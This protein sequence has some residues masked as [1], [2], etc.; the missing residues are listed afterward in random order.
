MRF[1]G[2]IDHGRYRETPVC[3]QTVWGQHKKADSAGTILAR[4]GLILIGGM[5][6]E[7]GANR[8][9]RLAPQ[10]RAP[11]SRK[12]ERQRG[13]RDFGRSSVR[14]DRTCDDRFECPCVG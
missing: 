12:Q 14:E 6:K 9:E 11:W 13:E 5:G 4:R 8:N 2:C 1:A 3:E 10:G 7:S